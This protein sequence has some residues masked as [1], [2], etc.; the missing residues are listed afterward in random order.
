MEEKRI[1]RDARSN[2]GLKGWGT[3]LYSFLSYYLY[4]SIAN[5]AL[6]A[7][8]PGMAA[9]RGWNV[10][11][12]MALSTPAGLIALFVA[13]YFGRVAAK[14][15]VKQ[16]ATIILI[17]GGISVIAWGYTNNYLTY[18]IV[19]IITVCMMNAI[20]LVGGTMLVTN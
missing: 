13:L 20:Q 9:E 18:A 6:N 14:R 5:S 2:F 8:V 3:V 16:T 12:I 19:L 7:V 11:S 1:R 17:I 4:D 15:G 10:E